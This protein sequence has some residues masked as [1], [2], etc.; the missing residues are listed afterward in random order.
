M[1]PKSSNTGN[2]SLNINSNL[3]N[4]HAVAYKGTDKIQDANV[5]LERNEE[6]VSANLNMN[7]KSV[8]QLE[9]IK[10]GEQKR[11]YKMLYLM[12]LIV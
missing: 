7:W 12:C 1:V 8:G 4:L 9:V 5:L 3:V 10:V 11:Y 2:L 6:K